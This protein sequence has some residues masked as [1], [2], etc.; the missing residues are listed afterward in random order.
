MEVKGFIS[1]RVVVTLTADGHRHKIFQIVFA[2]DG[3]FYVTFP[4]FEHTGGLLA[5]V[6]VDGLPGAQ[7]FVDLGDKAKLRRML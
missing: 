6:T 3:S 7:A 4:Y 2:K 5:E 1:E